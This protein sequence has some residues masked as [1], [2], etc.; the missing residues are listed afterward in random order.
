MLSI[1]EGRLLGMV[2]VVLVVILVMVLLMK[3][4]M[5]WRERVG[6]GWAR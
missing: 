4:V 6:W 5:V 1:L 3:V 2:L